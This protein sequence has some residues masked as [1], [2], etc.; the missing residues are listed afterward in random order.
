MCE[1]HP[2]SRKKIAVIVFYRPPDSDLN[3]IKEFKKTLQLIR[4][5]NKFDQLIVC[6]DFNLLNIDWNTG[7]T[8]NNNI[9]NQ[10]FTKT[11]KDHYLW[12][13]VN[14]PTRGENTLDL[15]LTNIP[16]K[17]Q[18]VAGFDDVLET[19]H[20][21]INFE[22]NLKIQ[23]KSRVER[24]VYDFAKS[25]WSSL[26]VLLSNSRWDLCFAPENIDETLTNW[27]CM[28]LSA[29]DKYI[30][31]HCIKRTHNHPWI[32][33][34]LLKLI[35]RKDIQR[36]KLK[37]SPSP[38]DLEKYKTLRRLTK[39]QIKQKK[40]QYNT[41]LTLH[42]NPR[43]FWS[44]V[45]CST[46]N[47][48]D[49]NFLKTEN[50]YTTDNV[51]IANILNTFFHSVFNPK[52]SESST[53][54]PLPS[55][56]TTDELSGIQL[57][58]LEVVG[59]L[60][61]LNS[62]K[63]CG[64][65]N[66]PN[67]L[68]IELIAPSLC[69]VFNMSLAL[70]VVP[71]QWKMANVTPVHKR[72]DP[73]LAT[74]YRPISLLCTLSKVLER[75]V[76]N[77]SYQ[78]LEPHMYHMQHGFIRGKSSTTQLLEVYHKILE[79]ISNG[80]EVDAI[81]LD[82]SKAFDQVP[83]HLLLK[84]LEMLGITGS[85]LSWFESYLTDRQQRVVIHGVCS[86]WLPVTSG[87]PQGSILGPLLFLVYCNDIP[88]CI[89]ENSTLALFADD[90]KL[91]R[92]LSSP[93]SSASLQ[94]DLCNIIRWTTNNQ[95]ELNAVKCK[96]MRISRKRTPTQTQYVI[97]EN[98]VEQAPIIKDLGVLITNNLSWSKHIESIVSSANKTLGL[99]K[100]I[101]KV[102]KNTN[103]R[104]ILYCALV[105]PK[106]EYACSVW[107]PYT[108][109]HRLLIENVQRRASKFILNY[110]ESMPY[111]ERLQKA[112]LLPLEFRREINDLI[113]WF[114]SKHHLITMDINKYISTYNPRYQSRNYDENNFNI[115]I[116]HKQEYFQ[117]SYFVRTAKI[118]NNLPT[119]LKA[120]NSLGAF[121]GRLNKL[122]CGKAKTYKLPDN[123][124]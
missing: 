31:K 3:Y 89:E 88:T 104:K 28:F 106:L 50:S 57:T 55:P 61:N 82:F 75:C 114:K 107:S 93:T 40:E 115:I 71:I 86:E 43:R 20:K 36:R 105:R 8:T 64:P 67:R 7:V 66:I 84:K 112:K 16:D 45:K 1:I 11:V 118:W 110:P 122:Y 121:K 12:Q 103:T 24:L 117:N 58:E 77:H 5:Q 74:N 23:R 21:L 92:T 90:S 48:K 41:Y 79:S 34:E 35:K 113:I 49:I 120:I 98:I 22:I 19:D 68:L 53:T 87:V 47:R 27:C 111:V 85:L 124:S 76:Y 29:V 15:S 63:A 9:I 109:K 42:E 97:N 60:R 18:N 99:V 81:Y 51:E 10:H 37:K 94:H 39:Q 30:P 119:E 38:C 6:G 95:M 70:G 116:R 52:D 32:D 73:T 13:L 44:A 91:Y 108:I 17:I 46:E 25:D 80:Y 101:C 78:H 123:H 83:H 100:R 33:K 59:V 69:D 62:Q 56:S 2:E 14:F 72:E 65:D 96:A 26:K 102:V 54:P 4:S